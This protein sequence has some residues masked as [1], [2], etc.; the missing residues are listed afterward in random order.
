MVSKDVVMEHPID[1]EQS[2]ID[3]S[4]VYHNLPIA[5]CIIGRDGRLLAVNELH[6]QL[7]DMPVKKLIGQRVA[8]LHPEGGRNVERDFLTFDAGRLVPNH[9]LEIR[10]RWYMVSVSPVRDRSGTV[11]AI[12]VAHSDITERKAIDSKITRMNRHLRRLSSHDHLTQLYNRRMFEKL[13]QRQ[14]SQAGRSSAGFSLLLFDIDHFKLYNDCYGHRAGDDCLV[15]VVTSAKMVLQ[16][17]K[18]DFCRYG[19]EEFAVILKEGGIEESLTVA[20]HLRDAIHTR[21]IAHEKTQTGVVT[22]SGGVCYSGQLAADGH[23]ADAMVRAA[24][25]A[26]YDAKALGRNTI[27]AFNPLRG[28][29]RL[30]ADKSERRSVR[31]SKRG[32]V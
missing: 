11:I 31:R 24:D 15:D 14:A 20:E 32:A 13:L 29:S 6:S 12:S 22:I 1:L 9:E 23:A 26:L 10:G 5:L 21:G 4:Q 8:D 25:A 18:A 7:G 2:G 3:L 16:R 28:A 27:C 30:M 17:R 19:G